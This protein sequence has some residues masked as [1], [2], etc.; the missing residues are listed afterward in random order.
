V[1]GL[2]KLSSAPK[3]STSIAGA[4]SLVIVAV[5]VVGIAAAH[6]A[7][8][9]L[10]VATPMMAA[11]LLVAAVSAAHS[12]PA[13]GAALVLPLPPRLERSVAEAFAML[14]AG[15]ARDLLAD[16]VARARTLLNTVAGGT[17]DERRLARDVTDLV[18]ACS[19]IAREHA[20]LDAVLPALWEPALAPAAARGAADDVDAD[21]LR[22]R[23]DAG[24]QLLAQRLRE[25]AVVIEEMVVQ[26]G[27]ERGGAAA[28]R[29]GELTSELAAEAAARRHAAQEIQRLMEGR[30]ER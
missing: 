20:R 21:E 11:T 24:R 12:R 9:A 30:G 4:D 16:V 26:Q 14:P 17:T 18:D 27:V 22:R 3:T 6:L 15:E 7:V 28:Q 29:V 10:W 25:A 13:A 8:P 1:T 5:V 2:A 19:E 23:G